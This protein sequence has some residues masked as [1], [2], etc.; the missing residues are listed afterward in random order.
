MNKRKIILFLLLAVLISSFLLFSSAQAARGRVT[1]EATPVFANIL[2]VGTDD[3][4]G[5]TD[6]LMLVSIRSDTKE[7]TVMQIPRDTYCAAD[8]PQKKINQIYPHARLSGM[9]KRSALAAL[10]D[11]ISTALGVPLDGY[12]AVDLEGVQ[13]LIDELGGVSLDVPRDVRHWDPQEER[14]IEIPAGERTLNGREAVEFLRFRSGYQT[15][16]LGRMD[17]QKLLLASVFLKIRA[18]NSPLD[19][20]SLI[21]KV[22]PRMTTNLSLG[23]QLSLAKVYLSDRDAFSVGMLT[24]PGEATRGEE[25]KGLWYYVVNRASAEEVAGRY[26]GGTGFDQKGRLLDGERPHFVNIYYD[27]PIAYTVYSEDAVRDIGKKIK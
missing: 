5:N 27:A 16:D 19:L 26:F 18:M 25:N 17:A 21:S 23:H 10:A 22:Y 13:L 12:L 2:C 6:V 24:L 15:G 7:I 3:A 20:I 8:T 4:A 11:T 14:Y 9:D 1:A